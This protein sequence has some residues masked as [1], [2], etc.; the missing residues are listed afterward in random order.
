MAECF[1]LEGRCSHVAHS[2]LCMRRSR[3]T[4][5]MN[6]I[7]PTKLL[8]DTMNCGLAMVGFSP[9]GVKIRI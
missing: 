1:G 7:R 8:N 3:H 9:I 5:T 6:L 2:D 4:D